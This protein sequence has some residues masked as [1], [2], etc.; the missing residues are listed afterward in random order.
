MAGSKPKF[1]A[2]LLAGAALVAVFLL[3]R[4]AHFFFGDITLAPLLAVVSL[5]ALAFFLRPK[6]VLLCTP[7]F[8]LLSFLLLTF[9]RHSL[10]LPGFGD[11]PEVETLVGFGRG[12][13]RS[14]TVLIAGGLCALL[15]LQ[16]EQLQK[17]VD[18]TVAVMTALPLGVLISDSSGLISFAN[19]RAAQILN[20]AMEKLLGSS[21]FSL[22]NAPEGNTIE[23]YAALSELPGENSGRL[24]MSL[25]KEPHKRLAARMFCFKAASGRLVA[26]VFD[27]PAD[28]S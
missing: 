13:V 10:V 19:D 27:E 11:L 18:E 17:A 25:R 23:K 24:I 26:T 20:V 8:A 14:L 2:K 22:L 28:K 3:D 6:A 1:P 12:F 21:Y 4:V 15:S 16:R 9:W 7:A 5:A